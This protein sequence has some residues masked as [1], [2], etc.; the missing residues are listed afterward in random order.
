MKRDVGIEIP[1]V[2]QRKPG[3]WLL[4]RALTTRLIPE[5]AQQVASKLASFFIDEN[6][7][8]REGQA[9]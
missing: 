7:Q 9:T 3:S 5:S 8:S 2:K 1:K 4:Q 6:L